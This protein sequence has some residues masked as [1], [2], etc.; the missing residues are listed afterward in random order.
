[1]S[2]RRALFLDR[3]GVL[4]NDFPESVKGAAGHV[5]SVHEMR[6]IPRSMEALAKLSG[7]GLFVCVVSN[8]SGIGRGYFGEEEFEA[9]TR[10]LLEGAASAGARIDAVYHCPH[11]P[12]AGCD[13]R[14]PLPGMLRRASAEHGLDLTRSVMVGDSRTD[15]VAGNAAGCATVLVLS[16]KVTTDRWRGWDIQP[17]FVAEDL[18]AAVPWIQEALSR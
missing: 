15:I 18:L 12:E 7:S 5:K 3:D 6:L 16:G 13:C 2:G 8:Q 4:N 14:K 9:M 10:H 17:S 1:M 11:H